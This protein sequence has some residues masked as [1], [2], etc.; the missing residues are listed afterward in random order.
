[1]QSHILWF[2]QI[3]TT[4]IWSKFQQGCE[5]SSIEDMALP[6]HGWLESIMK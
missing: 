4:A 2:N 5:D 3:L 6:T 1:M